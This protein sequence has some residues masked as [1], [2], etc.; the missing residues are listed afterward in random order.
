MINTLKALLVN[1][2]FIKLARLQSLCDGADPAMASHS[3]TRSPYH[4][5]A[6]LVA[7]AA[8]TDAQHCQII[9]KLNAMASGV[10][11]DKFEL[12]SLIGQISWRDLLLIEEADSGSYSKKLWGFER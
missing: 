6:F 3:F 12:D 9:E 2:T 10:R 11:F 5:L 8:A 7:Y 1:E 4:V